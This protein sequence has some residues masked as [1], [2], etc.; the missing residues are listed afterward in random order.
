MS[1]DGLVAVHELT[2]IRGQLFFVLF[3]CGGVHKVARQFASNELPEEMVPENKN[4]VK[5]ALNNR[6]PL[7]KELWHLTYAEED[8]QAEHRHCEWNITED[9]LPQATEVHLPL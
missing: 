4:I 3:R 1:K 9:G 7:S 5:F 6:Q 2:I 8:S